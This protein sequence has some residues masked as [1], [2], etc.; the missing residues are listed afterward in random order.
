MCDEV[1]SE[2]GVRGYKPV[3][4][5]VVVGVVLVAS[6]VALVSYKWAAREL[7]KEE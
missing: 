3:V 7:D 1:S 5:D 6:V 4:V 2:G